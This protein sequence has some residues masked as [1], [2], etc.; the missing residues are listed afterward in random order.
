MKPDCVYCKVFDDL[1]QLALAADL[2]I[3]IRQFSSCWVFKM[4]DD[5]DDVALSAMV[6][7][8]LLGRFD[9]EK[10]GTVMV[11]RAG[12][13][14]PLKWPIEYPYLHSEFLQFFGET[15]E[16]AERILDNHYEGGICYR[17]H[18]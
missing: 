17:V 13:G 18:Q 9:V 2:T 11:A 3:S 6:W 14:P 12:G 1:V 15:A 7:A 8:R 5:V 10:D 16:G 4:P